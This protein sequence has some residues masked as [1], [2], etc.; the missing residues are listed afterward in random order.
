MSRYKLVQRGFRSA[1]SHLNF[2]LYINSVY[3]YGRIIRLL[4]LVT[5]FCLN[6]SK[7]GTSFR[8]RSWLELVCFNQFGPVFADCGRF[9]CSQSCSINTI[10]D[11][12]DYHLRCTS[13]EHEYND[14]T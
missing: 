12:P 2:G 9:W 3:E 7:T 4:K 10:Y 11:S 8:G 13:A 6:W 1:Q 5:G 14:S